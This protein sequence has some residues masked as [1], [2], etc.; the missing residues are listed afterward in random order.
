PRRPWIVTILT[1]RLAMMLALAAGLNSEVRTPHSEL[2]NIPVFRY[3][4]E[5][6]Q[7]APYEVI[8]FHRG[9]L[10]G[11]AR[12]AVDELRK[13]P[14]NVKVDH[15]DLAKDLEGRSKEIWE[16]LKSPAEPWMV[17]LYPGGEGLAWAGHA[18]AG[19][20]RALIDSPARREV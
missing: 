8:V 9:P 14:A 19:A 4:L 2:C 18:G 1:M 6:W 7:A 15:I 20:V 13:E 17:A 16:S 12:A 5:R 10:E 11:A 3:A